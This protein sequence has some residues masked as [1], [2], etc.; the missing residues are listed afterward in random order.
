[1]KLRSF[2]TLIIIAFELLT[3][4]NCSEEPALTSEEVNE[5]LPQA[6]ETFLKIDSFNESTQVFV[7][8]GEHETVVKDLCKGVEEDCDY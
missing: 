4:K 1:M 8:V 6:R 7:L 5:L 3:L 2:L